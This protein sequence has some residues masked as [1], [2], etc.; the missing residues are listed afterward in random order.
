MIGQSSSEPDEP[1]LAMLRRAEA[2]VLIG[3]AAIAVLVLAAWFIPGLATLAPPGWSSM[4]AGTAM[5]L[6]VAAGS[7]AL[8]AE[9]QSPFRIRI[10]HVAACAVTAL[11]ALTLAEY[12]TGITFGIDTWLPYNHAGQF[13]G[14]PSPQTAIGFVFLGLCLLT[15]R[16][17]TNGL[18]LFADVL[19]GLLV[20]F[21]LTMIG[22]Y[23]YGAL[24]VTGIDAATLLS[25]HTLASFS[26]ATFVVVSRRA[27][28]GRVLADLVGIGIGSQVARIVLPG[29]I[30]VP[31]AFFVVLGRLIDSGTM[32]AA[33]ARS[34]AA[35][36]ETFLLL[37]VI[38]WMAWHLNGLERQLRELTLT[39]ELTKL[40]NRRGFHFLAEQAF[41]NAARTD[42]GMTVLFFDLDG[43]KHAN[44]TIGHDGGSRLIQALAGILAE[45]FRESDIIGRVGGDE[46]TVLTTGDGGQA[47]KILARVVGRLGDYNASSHLS[48]PLSF[49]VGVA[50]FVHGSAESLDALI[51]RADALMYQDKLARKAGRPLAAPAAGQAWPSAAA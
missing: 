26:A 33:L 46:F 34:L 43:L 17:G 22:G 39:D 14:R 45:S 1:L 25:P 50:E 6:V 13:P 49:S 35:P 15:I 12:V 2:P 18:S 24:S 30:V 8:S 38:V 48:V 32:T 23:L 3:M 21:D 16:E 31:F 44:D 11:G 10:S 9:R 36:A 5:G 29:I 41:R 42:A 28:K 19:A 51:A 37:G 27:Q 20:M 40:Y 4:V 7:L 47:R